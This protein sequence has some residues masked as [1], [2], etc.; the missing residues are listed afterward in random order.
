MSPC[1]PVCTPAT[2]LF[3][4]SRAMSASIYLLRHGLTGANRNKVFA[5]RSDEPLL[6]EGE[7]QIAEAADGLAWAG[8]GRIYC[9][10]LIRTRQSAAV[11]GNRL[12]VPVS[13]EEAINEIAI[14]HWDGLT[15]ERIR[16]D[17]GCEY[18]TWLSDP[19]GFA[20]PGCETIV[21]VQE[22]AAAF[23]EG[24]FRSQPGFN[25]LLISHLIVIRALLL[26]YQ[27]QPISSFREIKMENA[28]VVRLTRM[29]DGE[30]RVDLTCRQEAPMEQIG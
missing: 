29:E 2:P 9:G 4:E 28:Q 23:T 13:V 18:P 21:E 8:I 14:P 11:A 19:A 15:K 25:L 12:G 16:L 30:T 22:R 1:L 7:S 3:A 27:K 20:L 10:P 17:F 26:Y 5:G 6:P 24:L